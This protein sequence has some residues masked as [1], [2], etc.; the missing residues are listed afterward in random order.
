MSF[1]ASKKS[2]HQTA[3]EIALVEKDYANAFF[4]TAKA[5][6]FGLAL[7]EQNGSNEIAVPGTV[8]RQPIAFVGAEVA[9]GQRVGDSSA[10]P[11]IDGG[12]ALR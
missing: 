9:R 3:A 5:A 11:A 4:H 6:E 1:V 7:A 8:D 2:E 12:Q 10:H